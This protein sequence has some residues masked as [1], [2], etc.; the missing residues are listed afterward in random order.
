MFAR[1]AAIDLRPV[2]YRGAAAATA[3]LLSGQIPI[4]VGG[5]SDLAEMHK[6]GRVRILATAAAQRSPFIADVPTFRESGYDIMAT[7]WYAVF[8]PARTP[9]NIV[10]RLSTAIAGAVQSPDVKERLL[11]IGVQPTG[12]SAEALGKIQKQDSAFWAADVKASGFV[13]D[14]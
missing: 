13:A 10:E 5:V 11:S 8:A 1:A 9:P 6:A 3:D 12:T 2:P 14:Q 7:S 4:V